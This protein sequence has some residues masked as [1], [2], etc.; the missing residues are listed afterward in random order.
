MHLQI[1]KD[2][3]RWARSFN[4]QKESLKSSFQSFGLSREEDRKESAAADAGFS[5]FEKK[6]LSSHN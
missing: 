5:L 2:M 6:V 1:A 3:A 4:R